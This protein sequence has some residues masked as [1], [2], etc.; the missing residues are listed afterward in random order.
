M[1]LLFLFEFQSVIMEM[2]GKVMEAK[3]KGVK[4]LTP[5]IERIDRLITIYKN[6]D[7]YY[8]SAHFQK[9]K[10]RK[11]ERD[12]IDLSERITSLKEENKKLVETINWK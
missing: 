2:Q 8:Y 7:K 9:E 11:L 10:N 1:E 3:L 5:S 6:F 12:L 4:D